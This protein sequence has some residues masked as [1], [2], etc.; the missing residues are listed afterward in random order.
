MDDNR[1]DDEVYDIPN[2]I[3]SVQ[4]CPWWD[5]GFCLHPQRSRAACTTVHGAPPPFFCPDIHRA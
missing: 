2:R 1:D 4:E 5:R 3:E